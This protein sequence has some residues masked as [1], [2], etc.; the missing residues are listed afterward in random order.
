MLRVGPSGSA[1]GTAVEDIDPAARGPTAV[2]I[3]A[4]RH[5]EAEPPTWL[6]ARRSLEAVP[7]VKY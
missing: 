1:T 5:G 6:L 2:R 4:V 3:W 7:E